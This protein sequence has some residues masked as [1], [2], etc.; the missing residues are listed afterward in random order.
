MFITSNTNFFFTLLSGHGQ[1]DDNGEARPFLPQAHE[2]Q[3]QDHEGGARPK[4]VREVLQVQDT[5]VHD[6]Q[7]QENIEMTKVSENEVS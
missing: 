4:D 3:E 1:S 7:G 6:I 2:A 5:Q